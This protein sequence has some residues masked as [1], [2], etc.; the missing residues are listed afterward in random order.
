MGISNAIRCYAQ[1]ELV[2]LFSNDKENLPT[3]F[4]LQTQLLR[5]DRLLK[6]SSLEEFFVGWSLEQYDAKAAAVGKRVEEW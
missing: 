4:S 6:K 1:N 2:I 3:R 5:I